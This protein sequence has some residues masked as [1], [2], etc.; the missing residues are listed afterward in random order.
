[1]K[2]DQTLVI[3]EAGSNH[4]GDFATAMKLID[5]ASDSGANIV[6][7]QSYTAEK[8]FTTKASLV[9]NHDVFGLFKPLEMPASWTKDLIQYCDS[10]NVEFMS[11][12]FDDDA[13]DHLYNSGVKRFKVSGFESTDL[14]HIKYVASTRLPIIIS[15]GIGCSIVFIQEII[16]TCGKA[17]CEDI[18]ILH[19]NNAYPT[20]QD[21]INLDTIQTILQEYGDQVKV[22]LSDHT[23]SVLTPALAVAMGAR[24]IE[25]HYT[26]SKHLPGPDHFFALEPH[27]LSEMI[28]L[29]RTCEQSFG[30]KNDF[31]NSEISC[32]QGRR[33]VVLKKDVVKGEK[34]SVENLTTKRPYYGEAIQAKH[35]FKLID[36]HYIFASDSNRDEFLF[37]KDIKEINEEN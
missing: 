12:P 9:N 20:P 15:A 23:E 1:M 7:F 10:K 22:G 16:E 3:A 6:K 25:K 36:G 31:T 29:I 21:E 19:C 2:S 27:E 34:L 28:S 13:V 33:S 26:L 35:Y 37:K 24:C 11:T 17:G 18:T 8:L 5:V 30:Y 14:R 4:N 32:M